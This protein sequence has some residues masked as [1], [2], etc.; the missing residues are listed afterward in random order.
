MKRLTEEDI[1]EINN[2]GKIDS[3]YSG[4]WEEPFGVPNDE[5]RLLIYS[6]YES[7]GYSGGSCWG[8]EARA[9]SKTMP[10]NHMKILDLVLEKVCP[11]LTYLEYKSISRLIQSNEKTEYEYYGNSTNFIVEYLPLDDLYKHLGI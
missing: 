7:G 5:K 1:K 9:Y 10:K 8:N 6:R 11:N 2:S 3:W 4:I